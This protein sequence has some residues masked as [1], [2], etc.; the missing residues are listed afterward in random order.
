M[1]GHGALRMIW[2][3]S[4]D[5]TAGGLVLSL[6]SFVYKNSLTVLGWTDFAAWICPVSGEGGGYFLLNISFVIT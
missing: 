5:Q 3:S 4:Q 2:P 6:T 1:L